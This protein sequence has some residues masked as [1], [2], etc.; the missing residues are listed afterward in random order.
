MLNILNLI[1]ELKLKYN[2]DCF[3]II[4]RNCFI[5]NFTESLILFYTKIKIDNNYQVEIILNIDGVE[6]DLSNL[7]FSNNVNDENDEKK[8]ILELFELIEK[9]HLQ[10]NNSDDINNSNINDNV[11]N[12]NDSNS[13][14]DYNCNYLSDESNYSEISMNS[15]NSNLENYDPDDNHSND[16]NSSSNDLNDINEKFFSRASK[17]NSSQS[18]RNL[19]IYTW[20]NSNRKHKPEESELNFNVIPIVSLK[21]ESGLNLKKLNGTNREIQS[22]LFQNKKFNS[23]IDHIVTTIESNPSLSCI[24]INCKNGIHRS[25]AVAEIL[26]NEYYSNANVIHLELGYFRRR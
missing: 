23:F 26:R 10:N 20:G 5:F 11:N 13:Y 22:C 16:D 19:T 17:V 7:Y 9:R 15:S 2:E 4:G 24:S 6:K 3:Q 1:E 25:V 8:A 21:R 14:G 12:D 18:K